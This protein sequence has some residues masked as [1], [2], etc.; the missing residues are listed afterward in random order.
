MRGSLDVQVAVVLFYHRNAGAHLL[1]KRV[2]R[3]FVMRQR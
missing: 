1:S 3:N 2:N